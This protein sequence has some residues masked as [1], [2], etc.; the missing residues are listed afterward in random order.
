MSV[1]FHPQPKPIP[2]AIV[3]RKR[4]AEA[5]KALREAYADVD[6]RDGGICWVT[7]RFTRS[8]AVD[9]RVRREH[10]H[11]KGRRV[12]PDWITKPERIITICVEAH[13]LINA[14]WLVVE[15]C[16]ARKAIFFHWADHVSAKDKPFE[17]KARRLDQ[18]RD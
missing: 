5:D 4:R 10:H 11:L 17:I 3:K 6:L 9:P 1:G 18:A 7:G 14:G 13:Q 2:G 16:D 8:D 12:R 15:G